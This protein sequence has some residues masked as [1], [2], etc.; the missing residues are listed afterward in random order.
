MKACEPP[1]TSAGVSVGST[2]W[3]KVCRRLAP[4]VRAAS[5]YSAPRSC[6]TGCTVR[7]TKGMLVKTIATMIPA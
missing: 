5:S 2:T 1:V 7:T 4:R 6:S 3:R